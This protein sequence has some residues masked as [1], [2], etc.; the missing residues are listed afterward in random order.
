MDT[1]SSVTT[2]NQS[3]ENYPAANADM[4]KAKGFSTVDIS[5][6]LAFLKKNGYE[7]SKKP[8]F[9]GKSAS[10]RTATSTKKAVK[11]ST[12]KWKPTCLDLDNNMDEHRA[13]GNCLF[14]ALYESLDKDENLGLGKKSKITVRNLRKQIVLQQIQNVRNLCMQPNVDA[15]ALLLATNEVTSGISSLDMVTE[16]IITNIWNKHKTKNNTKFSTAAATGEIARAA[17]LAIFTNIGDSYVHNECLTCV[18]QILHR[19]ILLL[20]AYVTNEILYQCELYDDHDKHIY[21]PDQNGQLE[22]QF[23]AA[24]AG[25]EP[26]DFG[27][28]VKFS[29]DT[30]VIAMHPGHY[31][32]VP[33]FKERHLNFNGENVISVDLKNGKLVTDR[34]NVVKADVTECDS[35]PQISKKNIG[36]KLEKFNAFLKLQEKY[37]FHYASP[38]TD[39][40]YKRVFV[41]AKNAKTIGKSFCNCMLKLGF[42]AKKL[43]A[44]SV[45]VIPESVDTYSKNFYLALENLLK[46]FF[47]VPQ[48]LKVDALYDVDMDDPRRPRQT[49]RNKNAKIP[50]YILVEMQVAQ[51]DM[52]IRSLFYTCKIMAGATVNLAAV[53]P[54]IPPPVYSF[55]ICMKDSIDSS[56]V[57]EEIISTENIDS[58]P[59][60]FTEMSVGNVFLGKVLPYGTEVSTVNAAKNAL[61]K[62]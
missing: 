58:D 48:N 36:K 32:G 61:K 29:E 60:N 19:P 1:I 55:A 14:Y 2:R 25:D 27:V 50:A 43:K 17:A 52:A 37:N 8:N 56:L 24:R 40:T 10:E 49:T 20:Y 44:R 34:L 7:V 42:A 15:D 5:G 45:E 3:F 38:T 30:I 23:S 26:L 22:E 59:R 12:T 33:S 39:H 41:D 46:T 35:L 11:S 6:L 47:P 4:P 54:G 18:S 62:R 9:N 13:D 57:K 16:N 21:H 51:Q 28:D 53:A 31:Y